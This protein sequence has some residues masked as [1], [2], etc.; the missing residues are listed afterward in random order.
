[1]ALKHRLRELAALLIVFDAIGEQRGGSNSVRPELSRSGFQQVTEMDSLLGEGRT[2]A[3]ENRQRCL[4]AWVVREGRGCF[5]RD[6]NHKLQGLAQPAE[7]SLL[8]G[9]AVD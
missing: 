5:E 3:C 2:L 8:P 4:F 1:M 9:K 7:L 6:G